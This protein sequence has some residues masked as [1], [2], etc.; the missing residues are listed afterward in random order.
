ML[1]KATASACRPSARGV[2]TEETDV[3]LCGGKAAVSSVYSSG[4]EETP[5]ARVMLMLIGSGLGDLF[6]SAREIDSA[7]GASYGD[8]AGL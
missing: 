5:D 3:N 8:I 2:T 1:L 4:R 6:L 7:A